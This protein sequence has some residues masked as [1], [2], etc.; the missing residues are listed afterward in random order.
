MNRRDITA[1]DIEEWA[2]KHDYTEEDLANF[3]GILQVGQL[4]IS[5]L[6]PPAN[7]DYGDE[8]GDVYEAVYAASGLDGDDLPEPMDDYL[9]KMAMDCDDIRDVV[10]KSEEERVED[11][12]DH[13]YY[14][15][16][17]LWEDADDAGVDDDAVEEVWQAQ[18]R[19]R[20]ASDAI[21]D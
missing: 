9:P 19:L 1:E 5:H 16:N 7:R 4:L 14:I 21:E 8:I 2:D 20:N 18:E 3:A 13:V 10:D 17:E 12:I 15:V 11:R 6:V